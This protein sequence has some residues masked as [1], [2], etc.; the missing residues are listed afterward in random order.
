[1]TGPVQLLDALRLL[2]EN[3]PQIVEGRAA[4]LD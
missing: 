2:S 1:M 4:G 3:E